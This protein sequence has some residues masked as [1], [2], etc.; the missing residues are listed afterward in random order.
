MMLGGIGLLRGIMAKM[1]WL[2]QN[3]QVIAQNVANS[4]TPGFRPKTLKE[5]DFETFLG[6]S[7]ARGTSPVKMAATDSGHIGG[8][9]GAYSNPGLSKQKITYEASPDDNGV[10]LEEQLFKAN[11]NNMEFQIASDLYRRSTGM[12]RSVLQGS[13]G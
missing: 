2:D 11:K 6:A 4:D 10:V 1:N 8:A 5:A 3:Q 7:L 13:R 12:I 9:N